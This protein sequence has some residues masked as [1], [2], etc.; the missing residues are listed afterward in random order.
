MSSPPGGALSRVLL[1]REQVQR[2]AEWGGAVGPHSSIQ[3]VTVVLVQ[4]PPSK[5][6]ALRPG[7]RNPAG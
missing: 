4:T 6:P 2:A 3:V 1:S 5:P 7:G